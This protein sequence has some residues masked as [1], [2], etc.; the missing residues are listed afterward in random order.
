MKEAVSRK[1]DAHKAMSR[2]SAEENKKRYESNNN[3]IDKVV[4]KAMIEK[5]EE[6]LTDMKN[7]PNGLFRLVKGQK[8]DCK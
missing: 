5:F 3:K 8:I 1:K 2:N 6:A 4:S 7:C